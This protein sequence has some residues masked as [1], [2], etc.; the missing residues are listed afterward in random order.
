MSEMRTMR[1]GPFRGFVSSVEKDRIGPD[2][3]AE[4]SRNYRIDPITGKF[5]ER[6]GAVVL[7]DTFVAPVGLTEESRD[8]RTRQIFELPCSK[9]QNGNAVFSNN[10]PTYAA[11]Y[12]V[13]TYSGTN[14]WGTLYFRSTNSGGSNQTPAKSV[15]QSELSGGT[16][17][18]YPTTNR[19][20]KKSFFKALPTWTQD[21]SGLNRMGSGFSTLRAALYGG[22]RRAVISGNW[23]YTPGGNSNPRRWNM[24]FNDSSA[25]AVR[26]ERHWPIGLTPPLHPGYIPN[27]AGIIAAGAVAS[28]N[29][30][31]FKQGRTFY[32]SLQWIFE[33]GTPS[34]PFLPAKRVGTVLA[35]A[36]SDQ[37][38]LVQMPPGANYYNFLPWRNIPKAPPGCKAKRLLRTPMVDNGVTNGLWPPLTDQQGN[39]NFG[40]VAEIGPDVTS[41]DDYKWSDLELIYDPDTIR[42]DIVW[43]RRGRYMFTFDGRLG[44]A[45]T[46]RQPAM[47]VI[48]PTGNAVT[49]DITYNDDEGGGAA[50]TMDTKAYFVAFDATNL[51]LRY[52]AAVPGAPADTVIPLA[53][54]ATV[55]D[56]IDAVNATTV[57]GAAKEWRACLVPGAD[58]TL[59]ISVLAQ[60]SNGVAS[61]GDFGDESMITTA[62][63]FN[64]QCYSQAYPGLLFMDPT[65]AAKRDPQWDR[66]SIMHSSLTPSALAS[67]VQS[68]PNH[69]LA[70]NVQRQPP[71]AD[72]G[73][74]QGAATLAGDPL[75]GAVIFYTKKVWL[76]R[77]SR[78]FHTGNDEDYVWYLLSNDGCIA[79]DSIVEFNG[80]VGWLSSKGYKVTSGRPGDETLLTGPLYNPDNRRG[81]LAYEIQQCEI[82]S[83]AGS[84]DQ[85][86]HA[87]RFG[88]LLVI[89]YRVS[90]GVWEMQEYNFSEGVK[91]GGMEELFRPDGSLFGWSTRLTLPG[92]AMGSYTGANGL[93]KIHAIEINGSVGDGRLE[94]FD[95]G[96]QDNGTNIPTLLYLKMDD[97]GEIR[98]RKRDRK[99]TIK[100]RSPT[101]NTT[102]VQHVRDR[103]RF[104][105]TLYALHNTGDA[106]TAAVTKR[107]R[108]AGQAPARVHEYAFIGTRASSAPAEI[109]HMEREL[110]VLDTPVEGEP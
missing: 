84:D 75:G 107:V 13:S 1:H 110:K 23:L 70:R 62:I 97:Q 104:S 19:N 94:Q 31:G 90:A 76:Y 81:N 35:G 92:E 56:L 6:A 25:S 105:A 26:K 39:L 87:Q 47:V 30:A 15:V 38:G 68:A 54:L 36:S 99:F 74:F 85:R 102:K 16:S 48:A 2:E 5:F 77:N 34:L 18:I 95:V 72:S 3:A 28:A 24:L 109:W 100:Y 27:N 73:E 43:P 17:L 78:D 10:L 57:A 45:N 58:G 50:G 55:N 106:E 7:G 9:D 64:M 12:D 21:G 40:I 8:Y 83:K 20:G 86:F 71:D 101:G 14:T 53:G 11:L 80:A 108:L 96:Y 88:H 51:Y 89:Q 60:F 69:F 49:G 32:I 91:S 22:C 42:L 59:P 61:Y 65:E 44:I 67:R 41:Y 46:K 103:N 37:Y 63:R 82:A 98:R 33:D 93:V 29:Q 52:V 4:D 79:W 66:L